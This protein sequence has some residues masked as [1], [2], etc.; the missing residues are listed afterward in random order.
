MGLFSLLDEVLD[1]AEDV[2][3][4]TPR[5]MIEKTPE[6]ASFVRNVSLSAGQKALEHIGQSAG[7]IARSW[8]DTSGTAGNDKE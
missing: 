8:L 4:D 7:K 5:T 2:I 1:S 3:T 6:F